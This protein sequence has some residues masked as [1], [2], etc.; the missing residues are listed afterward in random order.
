MEQVYGNNFI[1]CIAR[2][3]TKIHE[4]VWKGTIEDALTEFSAPKGEIVLL[5]SITQIS[6]SHQVQ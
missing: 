4:Q 1:I 2:E 5:W 3:L 6:S